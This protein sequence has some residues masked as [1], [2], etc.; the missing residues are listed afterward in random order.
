M[1]KKPPPSPK[2]VLLVT[3][4]DPQRCAKHYPFWPDGPVVIQPM[5]E[6]AQS[7]DGPDEIYVSA[8][9][10]STEIAFDRATLVRPLTL[11]VVRQL[12]RDWGFQYP[13]RGASTNPWW[14]WLRYED[15]RRELRVSSQTRSLPAP[16]AK[17]SRQALQTL[18]ALHQRR[19][20]DVRYDVLI[21]LLRRGLVIKQAFKVGLKG[22]RPTPA[23]LAALEAALGPKSTFPGRTLYPTP[24]TR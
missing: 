3:P 20:G 13:M 7:V 6:V 15:D 11:D 19:Y 12:L 1:S 9:G 18:H 22:H 16:A 8:N 24:P 4:R 10:Y 5:I 21:R 14:F 17:L 2:A 23:G